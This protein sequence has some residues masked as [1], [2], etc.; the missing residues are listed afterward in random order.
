MNI[1]IQLVKNFPANAEIFRKMIKDFGKDYDGD[2]TMQFLSRKEALAVA[3]N[4]IELESVFWIMLDGRR[5]GFAQA[6]TYKDSD[7]NVISRCLDTRYILPAYRRQ[8]IGTQVVR[9]LQQQHNCQQ[10]RILSSKL[11]KPSVY[12]SWVDL[13]FTW[14]IPC[15]LIDRHFEDEVRYRA[16]DCH[17]FV[18]TDLAPNVDLIKQTLTYVDLAA[19]KWVN[20]PKETA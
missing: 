8:G 10:A 11:V 17:F 15:G 20:T 18:C 19:E 16:D 14:A 4:D 7:G 2:H 3:K 1:E 13:G 6:P 5:I 12:N 9:I